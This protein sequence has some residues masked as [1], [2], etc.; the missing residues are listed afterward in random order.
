MDENMNTTEAQVQESAVPDAEAVAAEENA[1]A[2]KPETSVENETGANEAEPAKQPQSPEENARFAAMRRQQEAQ[3][4]KEQIFHELVGDAVNP[5]TGKPF[6][7]KAE[8]VAWRDEMATR[9]RAQAAQMEPEAFKQLEAQLRE[10]IKATDPEIRAQAEELQRHRQREAQEQFS[11]DLKAIRKAY[12]DEKAKSVDELG[13]EFLKLCASGIK[14]LVAYEAIRAEK[15]RSTQNPPSMGDV[16]PTS[17]GEKE[18]F[19]REE[20]AAMDQATVS[21]NYEKIRKSM[22]TWK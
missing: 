10:Q 7:S 11:N 16:K 17:S 1:A 2:S 3:Q 5:N 14:P 21:K 6:A 4:R 20:V 19:T 8:F 9:Q 12:P 22:G 15:A 18:F 13:V